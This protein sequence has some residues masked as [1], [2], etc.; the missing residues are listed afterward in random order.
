M[1][2]TGFNDDRS[3]AFTI[4]AAGAKGGVDP[5]FDMKSLR[6][7]R[8]S[9]KSTKSRRPSLERKNSLVKKK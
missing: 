5:N 8:S 4:Y 3:E 9:S 6:S 7:R 1:K 2:K